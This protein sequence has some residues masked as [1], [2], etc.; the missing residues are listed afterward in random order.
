MNE[1]LF[2]IEKNLLPKGCHFTGEQ[3]NVIFEDNNMDVVAGPGAG[4]TTVLTAR[5]KI[6][7]NQMKET[8]KGICVLTHTNVAVDEIKS[9]LKKLG[10]PEVRSPHFIGTIQ[11]FFNT[12]FAKKAFHLL[13][14]DKKMRVFDD[15][16]FREKFHREFYFR[17][18]SYYKEDWNLPNPENR[19]IE[20]N[21][22]DL[23]K[24]ASVVG[25]YGVPYKNA[26]NKSII[27]LFNKGIITNKCCL[28]LA[29]WYIE[30]HRE[31]FRAV[32]PKRFSYLLLDEAQD[33]SALQFS[34]IS[35]L[36]GG[37][38]VT[39]QKFGDPYQAIY[40]IW[41]GDTDLAWA[42]NHSIEKRISK[43]SRFSKPI[44][45]I[46]KNVCVEKYD[47]LKSDSNHSSF[48]P[49][50]IV[51]DDGDDLLKKYD[52]LIERLEAT[53]ELFQ[54]SSKPKVIVSVKHID[55][56]KTFA[57]RYK[58]V[59]SKR[60]ERINDLDLFSE[61]LLKELSIGFEDSFEDSLKI[62]QNRI[63][64]FKIIQE[65]RSGNND[66]IIAELNKLL[67]ELFSSKGIQTDKDV[68]CTKIL[69]SL[70]DKFSMVLQTSSLE[71]ADSEYQDI[72]LATI[73]STKGET[74]KATL[75]MLDSEFKVDNTN[76]LP[77]YHILQLLKKYL[78][79]DYCT[80]PVDKNDEQK[81]TEKA[82]KLAY[83]ALSRPTHLVCIGIP[84]N[85]IDNEPTIIQDLLDV[86]WQQYK[87]QDVT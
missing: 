69:K 13:L 45:D 70:Q 74:H 41:G 55:L 61:V 34:L 84:S 44:V 18:P 59:I 75:L 17:K 58:R 9:S 16:I 82:L 79:K 86:G 48:S 80:L 54:R 28:A 66:K 77:G 7:L 78:L 71:A 4:K 46:V 83:V 40:N 50:F 43:T 60:V 29:K 87:E 12:F 33:T 38:N 63:H 67:D 5:I 11:E 56:E 22:D 27:S 15:D 10:V 72:R 49:Y 25:D 81:E 21:F 39:F 73:H 20:W 64:I 24:V 2:E 8:G 42:I 52:L 23:K 26:F 35:T 36:F 76:N 51:Y 1:L 14:K 3:K 53:D 65:L 31:I 30:K 62:I 68:L 47:D 37:T 19:E 6:L 32:I 85:Q 57:T